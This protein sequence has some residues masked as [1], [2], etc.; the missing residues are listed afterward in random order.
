MSQSFLIPKIVSER[1]QNKIPGNKL[2]Q[3]HVGHNKR[4]LFLYKIKNKQE[5]Y[6]EGLIPFIH[7]EL[8]QIKVNIKPQQNNE[9][10]SPEQ[11]NS[12]NMS[13]SY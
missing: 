7:K 5:K 6:Y 13:F 8:L 4:N 9:E 3:K 12:Q 10:K 1:D 2:N 11:I